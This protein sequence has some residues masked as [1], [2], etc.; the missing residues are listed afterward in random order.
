MVFYI[1]V[2]FYILFKVSNLGKLEKADSCIVLHRLIDIRVTLMSHQFTCKIRLCVSSSVEC[3]S[4]ALH[5]LNQGAN[6]FTPVFTTM[7]AI[8]SGF[9]AQLTRL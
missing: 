5:S 9:T 6:V 2:G 3:L 1:K 4:G 7:T 8:T